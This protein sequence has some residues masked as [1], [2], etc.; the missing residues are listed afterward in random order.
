M[1]KNIVI[2]GRHRTGRWPEAGPE[3]QQHLQAV[4]GVPLDPE[5]DINPAS[6]S[7]STTWPWHEGRWRSIPFKPLQTIRKLYSGATGTADAQRG[8]LRRSDLEH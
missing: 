3:H 5:S 4:L 1:A 2:F 6:K 8:R 7:R